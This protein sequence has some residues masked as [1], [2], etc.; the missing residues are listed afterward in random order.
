MRLLKNIIKIDKV[1]YKLFN[2]IYEISYGE[3]ER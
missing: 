3:I 1:Y 2:S